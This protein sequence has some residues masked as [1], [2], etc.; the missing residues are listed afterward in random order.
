MTQEEKNARRRELNKNPFHHDLELKR[1]KA[2]RDR[3]RDKMNALRRK[4]Y[5]ENR[6]KEIERGRKW[7]A[8]NPEKS[9]AAWKKWADK[10][11]DYL[12]E[13]DRI[14]R[15]DPKFAE[16]KRELRKIRESSPEGRAKRNESHKKWYH[17]NK[18]KAS[19][20]RWYMKFLWLPRW[21]RLELE[22]PKAEELYLRRCNEKTRMCYRLWKSRNPIIEN[23][24]KGIR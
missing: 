8:E 7:R 9:K 18:D 4:Q 5:A 12:R 19:I 6:E 10:N 23:I 11:R 24:L 16:R 14:R 20:L 3:N 21:E 13:R 22:G 15:K 2:W 1:Q 17:E